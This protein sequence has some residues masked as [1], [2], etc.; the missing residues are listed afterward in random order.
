MVSPK[1]LCR[2]HLLGE[3]NEIHKLIGSLKRQRSISGYIKNGC[4]EILSIEQ[5]HQVLVEEM[6]SRG[7]NHRSPLPE[8]INNLIG[9]LPK[10]EI[11]FKVDTKK[12]INDLKNR[13]TK[14]QLN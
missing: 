7:F 8:N 2:Q 6:L 12:S 13:C 14:C 1:I 11:E 4:L 9:Y 10:H 3:H 5:R